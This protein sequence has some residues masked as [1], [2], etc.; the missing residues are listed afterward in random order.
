MSAYTI[1]QAFPGLPWYF[2]NV[3]YQGLQM[4]SSVAFASAPSGV[5]REQDLGLSRPQDVK[6]DVGG[7][8]SVFG[9]VF[10]E[11]WGVSAVVACADRAPRSEP[12]MGTSRGSSTAVSPARPQLCAPMPATEE[13]PSS[14]AKPSRSEHWLRGD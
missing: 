12:S 11:C 1:S 6:K 10:A 5:L 9:E 8:R 14:C 13:P 4:D 3:N 2:F 7:T